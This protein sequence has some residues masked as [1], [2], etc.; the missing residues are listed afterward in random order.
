[1]KTKSNIVIT[2]S[3]KKY[4]EGFSIYVDEILFNSAINLSGVDNINDLT[5]KKA[6]ILITLFRNILKTPLR[7][8]Q[9]KKELKNIIELL[10]QTKTEILPIFSEVSPDKIADMSVIIVKTILEKDIKK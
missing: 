1:M 2:E 8:E 10:K 7:K 5:K 6:S 3:Q 9:E 4:L